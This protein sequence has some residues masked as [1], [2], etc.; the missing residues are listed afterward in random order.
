MVDR[1]RQDATW[2]LLRER[3]RS[4]ARQQAYVDQHR[5]VIAAIAQ[6]E[7]HA[8]EEAMREHLELVRDGLLKVMTSPLP[9]GRDPD[10]AISENTEDQRLHGT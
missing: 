8:A 5:R 4:G 3:A 2:R 1:I 9:N 7:A 6:R 10:A